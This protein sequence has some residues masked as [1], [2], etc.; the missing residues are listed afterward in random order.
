MLVGGFN[1][2]EKYDCQLGLLFPIYGKI[3]KM[4]ETTK[5]YDYDYLIMVQKHVKLHPKESK[6]RCP[7]RYHVMPKTSLGTASV[8][9]SPFTKPGMAWLM[10]VDVML[11]SHIT[12]W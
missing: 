2:F 9:T 7:S 1:P 12:L 5:H 4:F 3:K 6:Q 11:S 10:A 8:D